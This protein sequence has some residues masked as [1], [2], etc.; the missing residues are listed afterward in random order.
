MTLA[1]AGAQAGA[2]GAFV[3]PQAPHQRLDMRTSPG[4]SVDA[5]GH[6]PSPGV[7]PRAH[8]RKR[9]PGSSPAL[10]SN[11]EVADSLL[12]DFNE[13]ASKLTSTAVLASVEELKRATALVDKLISRGLL[14]KVRCVLAS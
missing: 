4:G 11:Q 6:T 7:R 5:M 8:G 14:G 2:P 9:V 12:E 3:S 13:V 1:G 10:Q